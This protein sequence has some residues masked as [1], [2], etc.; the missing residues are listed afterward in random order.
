MKKNSSNKL[1]KNITKSKLSIGILI[2]LIL[3]VGLGIK[4]SYDVFIEKQS[5][6]SDFI[7]KD[8]KAQFNNII[9]YKILSTEPKVIQKVT[10]D[11]KPLLIKNF[12]PTK[13]NSNFYIKSNIKQNYHFFYFTRTAPSLE[14]YA[15]NFIP[16]FE[17]L[18]YLKYET[19]DPRTK[20]YTFELDGIKYLVIINLLSYN[21]DDTMGI[22]MVYVS[23]F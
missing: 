7:N 16:E 6:K 9:D 21:N 19:Q 17:S 22:F 10:S 23:K 14:A 18:G 1:I 4:L 5:I 3:I 2:L 15:N 11:L 20:E 13:F 8:Q 12:G